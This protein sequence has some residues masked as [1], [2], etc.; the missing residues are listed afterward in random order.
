MKRS[1]GGPRR[2]A[3]H[4]PR[5]TPRVWSEGMIPAQDGTQQVRTQQLGWKHQLLCSFRDK[6]EEMWGQV[7]QNA[8]IL[9]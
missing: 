1:P 5:L 9:N 3:G 8:D 7:E 2:T 4:V 6:T